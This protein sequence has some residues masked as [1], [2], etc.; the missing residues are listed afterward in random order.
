MPLLSA[1]HALEV[2]QALVDASPA[3]ETEVT[4]QSEEDRFARFSPEGPSQNA[5]RERHEL[6]VRVRLHTEAG[7]KEARATVGTLDEE[8]ARAALGRAMALAGAASPDPD[9]LPLAGAVE[10]PGSA[11]H[12]PT[13]DH[14][15]REKAE[16]IEVAMD[17]CAQ[18]ELAPAGLAR[19]TVYTRTLVNSTGR[20]AEGALS[21][22]HFSLTAS[23]TDGSGDAG[24]AEQTHCD[25]ARID[26][27]EVISR[28]VDR[29]TRGRNPKPI[30]A[31][32]YTVV[33]E[34]LA[35]S[36]LM[37]FL[38]YAGLGAEELHLKASPLVGRIGERIFPEDLQLHDDAGYADHPGWRFDGEGTPRSRVALISDGAFGLPVTDARWARTLDLPDTGHSAP[39]P[40]SKGPAPENLVL[41]AG[42]KSMEQLISGVDNGLLI[43]QFHYT[44]LMEPRDMILTG[45]TRGGTFHIQGGKVTDS[46]CNLRFTQS[47]V[48]ALRHVTGIGRRQEIVGALFDGNIVCPALRLDGFRFTSTT[49]I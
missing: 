44:N 3:D 21:R 23:P 33:L 15:F 6:S 49:E 12:R 34:P 14:S 2:C 29:G 19:T 39:Q 31:Q 10:I 45:M 5:D 8:E 38:S 16:W 26:V 30:A 48:E 35:V 40:N 37:L 32:E 46:V 1:D 43:S 47:L 42:N 13:Q 17:R 18:A 11:P 28:A 41:A 20:V 4:L 22:A 25:V 7:W 27:D 36:S 24:V 9:R